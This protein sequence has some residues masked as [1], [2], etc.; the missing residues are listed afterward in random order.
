MDLW[1]IFYF[2]DYFVLIRN[3]DSNGTMINMKNGEKINKFV[4]RVVSSN[5][6]DFAAYIF[7][8]ESLWHYSNFN[9]N[10]QSEKNSKLWESKSDIWMIFNRETTP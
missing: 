8:S 3:S 9:S 7:N 5:A 6:N 2:S 4:L 1:K 10:L